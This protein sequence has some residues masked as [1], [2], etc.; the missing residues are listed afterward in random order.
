MRVLLYK[1]GEIRD[2]IDPR[3]VGR[4]KA[5]PEFTAG[6]RYVN[7]AFRKYRRV[8]EPQARYSKAIVRF[9]HLRADKLVGFSL[10]FQSLGKSR[11]LSLSLLSHNVPSLCSSALRTRKHISAVCVGQPWKQLFSTLRAYGVG[12]QNRSCHPARPSRGHRKS[13]PLGKVDATG[14]SDHP[15]CYAAAAVNK[16]S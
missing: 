1:R 14:C 10:F 15:Y 6:E 13:V 5:G 12:V 9:F 11:S 2:E 16:S 7:L 8:P 3:C 4:G